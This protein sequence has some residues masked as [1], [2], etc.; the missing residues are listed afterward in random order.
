MRN[1]IFYR[2]LIWFL[3]IIVLT[4]ITFLNYRI[5]IVNTITKDI[6]REKQ[7]ANEYDGKNGKLQDIIDEIEEYNERVYEDSKYDMMIPDYYD[8]R[9]II[10]FYVDRPILISNAELL[11]VSLTNESMP[12][13]INWSSNLNKKDVKAVKVSVS[14][15]V[16]DEENITTYIEEL[17]TSVRCIYISNIDFILPGEFL[18]DDPNIKVQMEYYL[19]YKDNKTT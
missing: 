10:L 7:I 13:N 11:S 2:L 5:I 16:L 3:L 4:F 14:F 6:E 15:H 19:F 18:P 17:Q 12:T 1:K 9:E 8:E